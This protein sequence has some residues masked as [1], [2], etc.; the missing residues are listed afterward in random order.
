MLCWHKDEKERVCAFLSYFCTPQNPQ[1]CM[2]LSFSLVINAF[3][4]MGPLFVWGARSLSTWDLGVGSWVIM[5]WACYALPI[6]TTP[7]CA[8]CQWTLG[9]WG[10][11]FVWM[12]VHN[13]WKMLHG[14]LWWYSRCKSMQMM[15]WFPNYREFDQNIRHKAKRKIV[16]WIKRHI[17]LR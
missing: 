4:E 7:V 15:L 12:C 17:A 1:A 10:W 2:W 8:N 9:G 6:N 13:P 5:W 3:I 11:V 16:S 14:D